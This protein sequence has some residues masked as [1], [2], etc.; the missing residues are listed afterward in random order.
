MLQR[1]LDGTHARR[2]TRLHIIEQLDFVSGNDLPQ[3]TVLRIANL[4]KVLV[5]E[6][7]VGAVKR[8][9]AGLADKLHDD[10]AGDVAVLVD[11]DSTFLVTQQKFL[12]A[13][14][15]HAQRVLP[16]QARGNGRDMGLLEI[17]DRPSLLLVQGENLEAFGGA[18][19]QRGMEEIDAIAFGSNVEIVVV[20]EEV[21][22]TRSEETRLLLSRFLVDR[23]KHLSKLLASTVFYG[24]RLSAN[25][26]LE[27]GRDT[28]TLLVEDERS[29]LH[30]ASGEEANI[31]LTRQLLRS[32]PG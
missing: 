11:V 3:A 22:S 30:L 28:V 25:M 14:S 20:A 17:G 26:Y 13:E 2:A 16:R 31:T 5:E 7:D 23:F 29:I 21:C 32:F 9:A 8:R 10:G 12:V 27:N 24:C 19:S 1:D 6:Q 4:D 15:E 18:D